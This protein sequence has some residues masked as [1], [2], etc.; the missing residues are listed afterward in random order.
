VTDENIVQWLSRHDHVFG[1]LQEAVTKTSE[2][3]GHAGRLI[4]A[5]VSA[6]GSGEALAAVR[7]NAR[8]LLAAARRAR[9]FP[10]I[11][12]EQ[13][14]ISFSAA[15]ERWVDASETLVAAAE[16]RNVSEIHRAQRALD[17]GMNELFRM[18]AALRRA[19]GQQHPTI[20]GAT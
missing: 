18:A 15:L 9:R 8:R 2:A 3:A 1:E 13:T 5:N 11:P 10:P 12:D 16:H 14:T 19:T 17:A 4:A 7:E 20:S 6:A